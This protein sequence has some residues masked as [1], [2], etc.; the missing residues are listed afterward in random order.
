MSKLTL[1][2]RNFAVAAHGMHYVAAHGV[3][4]VATHGVHYVAAHGVLYVLVWMLEQ[5][6]STSPYNIS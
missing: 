6:T 1:F 2:F 4:Y 3:H 5:R